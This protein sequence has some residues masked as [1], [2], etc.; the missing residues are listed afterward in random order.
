MLQARR[1]AWC[2]PASPASARRASHSAPPT[3]L[4][5]TAC[6]CSGA[7]ALKSQGRR[8]TGHGGK[9][10]AAASLVGTTRNYSETAGAAA[11]DLAA[12]DTEVAHRLAVPSV[13]PATMTAAEARFRLFDAVAGFWQR[14]AGRR[15]LLL[16]FD[17]LHQADVP[18]LKLLEYVAAELRSSPLM[19]LG[20]YR[21]AEVGRDHPL[22]DALA[23]AARHTPLQRLKLGGFSAT[24]T[25]R[26]HQHRRRR[27]V[28][29]A[30]CRAARAHRRASAV[31][32]RDGALYRGDTRRRRASARPDGVGAAAGRRAR[33][34]RLPAGAAV[35]SLFARAERRC[36]D[37]P[38]LRARSAAAAARRNIGRRMPRRARRGAPCEPARAARRS[39]VIPVHARIDSRGAARGDVGTPP[40][41][42]APAHRRGARRTHA[43][44]RCRC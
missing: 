24:E 4:R 29:T 28:A 18:S 34:D 16:V 27:P 39:D 40:R 41:A 7:A 11:A 42:A 44:D 31:P 19:I 3:M 1:S 5:A 13:P 32:G 25:M 15:P 10:C 9:C 2:S 26:V 6:S 33:G 35:A 17:D 14:A 12:L 21:D 38:P 37:R 43:G 23:Q 30:R 8:R 22:A 20:T 36:S